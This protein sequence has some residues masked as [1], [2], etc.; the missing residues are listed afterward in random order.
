MRHTTSQIINKLTIMALSDLDILGLLPR[1]PEKRS[2]PDLLRRLAAAGHELTPR[3]LQRRLISLSRSHPIRCDDRGKP[4]GW[5]IA[6]DASPT[7]G[8]MSVQEALALKLTEQY[9]Q[10]AIPTELTDDLKHYFKQADHKLKGESLYRAWLSKVR[11][12]SAVQPLTS[13]NIARNVLAN[14]YSGVLRGTVL[15]VSYSTRDAKAPKYYDIEP[16]AIVVRGAVTYLVA[17]FPWAD[18]VNLM[19]LHRFKS[20]RNTDAKIRP[21]DDFNLDTFLASGALGFMQTDPKRIAIRFYDGTGAHLSETPIS[22]DQLLRTASDGSLD[23]I[24]TMPI[25]EQFKWW[26]LGFGD[27][28]EVIGPASLRKE[29][30]ERLNISAKR[31]DKPQLEQPKRGLI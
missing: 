7:F 18:D 9:L 16:L 21:K 22:T 20:I 27:H 12:I 29:F 3:S 30:A 1:A 13:P 23:L 10:Q 26:V 6:A 14:A 28:A 19:A 17:Q 11:L 2:T 8:E 4:Y 15:N 24:V 31:Y 25:T 5:S